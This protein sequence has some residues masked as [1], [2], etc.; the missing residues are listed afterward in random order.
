MNTLLIVL[1]GGKDML[2]QVLSELVSKYPDAI[3]TIKRDT[4]EDVDLHQ[5]YRSK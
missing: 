4:K 2:N 1:Q 3:V 5:M